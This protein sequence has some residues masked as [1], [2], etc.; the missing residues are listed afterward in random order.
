MT[1]FRTRGWTLVADREEDSR[2]FN[3]RHLEVVTL[4]E[5]ADAIKTGAVHVAGSLS[6]DDF[7]GRMPAESGDLTRM[8]AYAAER[9]W[10]REGAGFAKG[11]R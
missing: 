2:S 9:G 11:R 1:F 10:Q 4:L 3:R 5:L 6:Y 8:T 7:W